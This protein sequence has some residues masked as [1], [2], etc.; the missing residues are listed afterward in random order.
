MKKY[1]IALVALLC[2]IS[3]SGCQSECEKNGHKWQDATYETPK[4]CS[5]CGETE[6]DVLPETFET[7]K[8][9]L[10]EINTKSS[11][12]VTTQTT[13]YGEESTVI[14]ITTESD[15]SY[16]LSKTVAMG[17]NFYSFIEIDDSLVYQYAK[18]SDEDEWEYIGEIDVNEYFNSD[19]VPTD[20]EITEDSFTLTDGIWIGNTTKLNTIL[21]T[22]LE[23]LNESYKQMG[24]TVSNMTFNRYDI[25]LSNGQIKNIWI[26]ISITMS[27]MGTTITTNSD[28]NM[29][30][31]KIGQTVVNKPANLPT[32]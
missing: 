18:Y 4:T 23:Q 11:T 1:F 20:F 9:A 17:E 26:R 16:S 32:H 5:I 7:L 30:Y 6:G 8:R 3:F 10:E 14:T 24:I 28:I 21:E 13:N 2:C 27:I 19:S 25:E 15:N 22:Y 12:V 29:L 31:S